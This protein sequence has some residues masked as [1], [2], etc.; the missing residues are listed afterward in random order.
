MLKITIG[1]NR[2]NSGSVVYLFNWPCHTKSHV[3][4]IEFSINEFFVDDG[5]DAVLETLPSK[6]EWLSANG[7]ISIND[8]NQPVSKLI[9]QHLSYLKFLI[10][11]KYLNLYSFNNT[12]EPKSLPLSLTT[13]RLYKLSGSFENVGILDNLKELTISTLSQSLV[14]ALTNI[15]NNKIWFNTIAANTSSP[16]HQSPIST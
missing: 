12:I 13:L 6:L 3:T 16:I 2:I 8:L 1:Y 7:L 14:D 11:F 4:K 5:V 10:F 9:K 15:K